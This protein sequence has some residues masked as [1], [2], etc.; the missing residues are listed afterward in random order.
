VA[1]LADE[2]LATREDA[3]MVAILAANWN[4]RETA[5]RWGTGFS[6]TMGLCLH[7]FPFCA[8]AS[9]QS[10]QHCAYA[11]MANRGN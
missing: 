4:D 6:R 1:V 10:F 7:P 2:E 5:D 8:P 3:E 11:V 9:R